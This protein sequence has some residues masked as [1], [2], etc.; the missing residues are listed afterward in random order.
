MKLRKKSS[1]EKIKKKKSNFDLVPV[2]LGA[3]HI[4]TEMPS[5]PGYVPLHDFID[6]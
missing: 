2:A 1:F 4:L 3:A 5:L 6:S